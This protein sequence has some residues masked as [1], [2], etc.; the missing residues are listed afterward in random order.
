MD[1]TDQSSDSL[2]QSPSISSSISSN[3]YKDFAIDVLNK[4]VVKGNSIAESNPGS[5]RAIAISTA[6]TIVEMSLEKYSSSNLSSRR[7]G[8]SGS[9]ELTDEQISQIESVPTSADDD[10]DGNKRKS[11]HFADR[12]IEKLLKS[13]LPQDIPE[14]EIFEKRLNDPERNKR[15]GLSLGVLT[16][17]VKQMAGKMT[18]FFALQYEVLYIIAWKKPTKTISAL[19]LYTA[20]C[21]WPHLVLAYPLIFVLFSVLIPGYVHRHP[22]RNPELI[23]VKKRGQSLLSFLFETPETSIVEDLINEE[24]LRESDEMASSTYSISE[25]TSEVTVSSSMPLDSE[26]PKKDDVAKHRKSQIALLINL[27]DF[28]NLTT[29][30][31]KGINNAEKF[32]YETGGFKDERLST[33]IFYGVLLSTF[34]ILF[35]GKYVPW[36]LI[37]IQGGW[38][39]AILCHPN[40]K[41]FLVE[42]S[43]ARKARAAIEKAKKEEESVPEIII[44]DANDT[45]TQFDRNDIIVDDSPETRIVEI[46][47]LQIKSILKHSWAFYRY[48]TTIYDKNNKARIAG[49]RPPGVDHLSKVY[50]PNDWKFDFGLVNKWNLDTEPNEFIRERSLNPNLFIVKNNESQGWIYDNMEGV[51]H[52]DIVYEFRRR[53]LYRECYRYGRPHKQPSKY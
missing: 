43:K 22:Q 31:L 28:Q 18:N 38:T 7:S 42:A 53:R 17:N 45:I 4:A 50:P 25:E 10:G 49:K 41:K 21:L 6:S 33:F 1:S 47:E 51:V 46:Y 34:G 48:S 26:S 16:S 5:K 11:G 19:V 32:Y 24:Y 8:R 44:K 23:K 3:S 2:Q 9:I 39:G 27:R 40:C 37:F 15:P 35:V 29:D 52:S 14:R 12:M 13:V 20:V 36:R 30:I